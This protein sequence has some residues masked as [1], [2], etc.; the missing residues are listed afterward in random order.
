MQPVI[1]LKLEFQISLEKSPGFPAA[2]QTSYVTQYFHC[3]RHA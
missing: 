1:Q 2:L 3:L